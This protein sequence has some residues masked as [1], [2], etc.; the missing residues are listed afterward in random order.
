MIV[1]YAFTH[2]YYDNDDKCSFGDTIHGPRF[3]ATYQL[4]DDED[5]LNDISSFI[6]S[7]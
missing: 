1:F 7:N 4:I 2:G 3:G 5:N 6:T